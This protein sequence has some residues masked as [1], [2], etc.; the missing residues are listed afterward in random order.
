MVAVRVER[1]SGYGQVPG[2]EYDELADPAE[3][4]RQVVFDE[5][6]P[7]LAL[8]VDRNGSWIRPTIDEKG[9]V[10]WGAFG[11]H[12]F[13]RLYGSI[14]K[15]RYKINKLQEEL[16]WAMVRM[17]VAAGRVAKGMIYPLTRSLRSGAIGLEHIDDM[18][19]Y[20]FAQRF[21]RVLSINNEIGELRAR[22]RAGAAA[23]VG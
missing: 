23:S 9:E 7:I 4:E 2:L 13:E 8:P 18:N 11:T 21:L 15:A 19:Q 3:L 1:N 17:E 22:R 10:D 20:F 6:G 12:D 14:D 5:W 16:R